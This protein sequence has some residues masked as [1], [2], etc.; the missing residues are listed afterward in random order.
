MSLLDDRCR[1]LE[2]L[3]PLWPKPWLDKR[4]LSAAPDELEGGGVSCAGEPL[5]EDAL[6]L[7]SLSRM[8]RILCDR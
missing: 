3:V 6:A 7:T 8:G 4:Y 5:L 2:R 1:S